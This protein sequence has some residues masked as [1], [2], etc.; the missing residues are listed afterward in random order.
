MYGNKTLHQS[1]HFTKEIITNVVQPLVA[2]AESVLELDEH[3]VMDLSGL[4][5]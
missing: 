1:S 4:L 5:G 3:V 2:G